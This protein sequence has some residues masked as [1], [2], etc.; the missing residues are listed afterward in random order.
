MKNIRTRKEIDE[1][2]ETIVRQFAGE[3]YITKPVDI[4][5]LAL[6]HLKLNVKYV[7][8]ADRSKERLGCISDGFTLY[9]LINNGR[10]GE[11][12]VPKDTILL[13][14]SLKGDENRA[15]RRFTLAHEVYHY[16]DNVV[17]GN[18]VY[19]Y[20]SKLRTDMEYTKKELD[21]SLSIDEWAADRGAAALLMPKGLIYTTARTRFGDD[22]IPIFGD[23]LLLP[24]DKAKIADMAEFL[25]VSYTALI[26]RLKELRLFK[27]HNANEYF[28]I[29]L[30]GG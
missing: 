3:D 16:I 29:A 22:G 19:S 4:A 10:I 14:M 26:I 17:N 27:Y 23:N 8:F 20:C 30:G 28:N 2:C 9:K 24:E 5:G 11:Y 12:V 6:T 1:L 21:E 15:R 25:G 7:R 18:K 13:D